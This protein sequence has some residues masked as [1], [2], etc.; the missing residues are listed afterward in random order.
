MVARR[1]RNWQSWWDGRAVLE[2]EA[3]SQVDLADV[4]TTEQIINLLDTN[5]V[6]IDR[7]VLYRGDAEV[8][9]KVRQRLRLGPSHSVRSAPIFIADDSCQLLLVI[10]RISNLSA[11][12]TSLHVL[13]S[14]CQTPEAE[15][16]ARAISD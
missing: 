14:V 6:Q 7:I 2:G 15:R 9:D 13:F 1:S 11:S 5:S 4:A 3:A 16:V 10:N 12:M 8:Y